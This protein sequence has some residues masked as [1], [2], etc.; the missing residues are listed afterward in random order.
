MEN[1][2]QNACYYSK[3]KVYVKLARNEEYFEITVTDD[4]DGFS[5]KSIDK[6]FS[7]YYKEDGKNSTS[8]TTPKIDK[9]GRINEWPIDFFDEWENNLAELL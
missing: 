9:N 8:I 1:I 7:P 2:I 3:K 6:V 5:E 4:G